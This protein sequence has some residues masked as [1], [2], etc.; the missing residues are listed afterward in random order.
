MNRAERRAKLF[1]DRPPASGIMWSRGVH[2]D[3]LAYARA[4]GPHPFWKRRRRR[5]A[6]K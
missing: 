2:Q 1:A 6:G 5:M 3:V 4:R